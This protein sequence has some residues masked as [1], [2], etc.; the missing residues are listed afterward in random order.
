[1]SVLLTM[2]PSLQLSLP[3]LFDGVKSL[4]L[5]KDYRLAKHSLTTQNF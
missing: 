1:M 4:S 2:E 3:T 5:A